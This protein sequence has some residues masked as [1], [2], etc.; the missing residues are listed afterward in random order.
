MVATGESA[1]RECSR[2]S[3]LIWQPGW[4]AFQIVQTNEFRADFSRLITNGA[5]RGANLLPTY[6]GPRRAAE[7]ASLSLN[8]LALLLATILSW[9]LTKVLLFFLSHPPLTP[10]RP[11]AGEH[12]NA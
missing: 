6:W 3:R 8:A 7:A 12:S 11:S 1:A 5:C 10:C 2:T 4:G 9:R